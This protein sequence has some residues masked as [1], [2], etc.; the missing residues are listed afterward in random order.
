ML[1]HGTFKGVRSFTFFAGGIVTLHP[2]CVPTFLS[3]INKADFSK[4]Q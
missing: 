4:I 2:K 1:L 3:Q